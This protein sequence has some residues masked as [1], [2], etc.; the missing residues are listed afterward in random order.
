VRD[1]SLRTGGSL[2]WKSWKRVRARSRGLEAER[3][4]KGMGVQPACVVRSRVPDGDARCRVC[5]SIES[6]ESIELF[7][8]LILSNLTSWSRGSGMGAGLSRSR[9]RLRTWR[10]TRHD[11][12]VANG[13]TP[14]RCFGAVRRAGRAAKRTQPPPARHATIGEKNGNLLRVIINSATSF[15]TRLQSLLLA[16]KSDS[17][18]VM[19]ILPYS[20]SFETLCTRHE[21][22]PL[23]CYLHVWVMGAG[24]W[25]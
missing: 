18:R 10:V 4:G 11:R 24:R 7:E 12:R 2:R 13:K 23:T 17:A 15:I 5:E 21:T 8:P 6:C 9:R 20:S 1:L 3:S 19:H 22:R 25:P 14:S 16:F